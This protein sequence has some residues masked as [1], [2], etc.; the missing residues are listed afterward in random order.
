ML[1]K[2]ELARDA[3]IIRYDNENTRRGYLY[4]IGKY[5]AWCE[6]CGLKPL[7]AKR[8]HI[9]VFARSLEQSGLA[10][11]SVAFILNGV[12]GLYKY[13]HIDGRIDSNPMAYVRRPKIQRESTTNGLSR[14]EFAD[15]LEAAESHSCRAHA[16]VCLLGYNG[17]RVSEACGID[18][19]HLGFSRGYATI[20]IKRK[21]DKR[22]KIPMSQQTAWAV[23]KLKRE[24]SIHAGPLLLRRDGKRM[25]NRTA[26]RIVKSLARV[27]GVDKKISPHS[28]RHT[29]VTLSLDAGVSERDIQNST[30]HA[31][32]RMISFYD[33]NRESL[34]RNATHALTAYVSGAA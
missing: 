6:D 17:L 1:S 21:G 23:D 26:D 20:K 29:F 3:F 12:A 7:K 13:A 8:E 25:D 16:L 34:A 5:Y 28:F 4:S 22:Q 32:I 18:V 2:S 11:S 30:G 24:C 33:R 15:I 31:D 27:A 19:E 14:T 10:K 9:E